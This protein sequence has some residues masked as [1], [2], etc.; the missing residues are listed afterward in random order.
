LSINLLLEINNNMDIKQTLKLKEIDQLDS[1]ILQFSKNTLITKRI[2]ASLL[3]AIIAIIMKVTDNKLDFSIYV[4]SAITLL[5]FWIID[6]HS[7]YYQ[8]LLRI[9]MSKIV[10]ELKN[11]ELFNGF[12]MPLA[13]NEKI[14]WKKSMFNNSQL[15]YLLSMV[16]VII[17]AICDL[18]GLF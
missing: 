8:R 1:A 5:V 3:V 4:A 14:T 11:D 10:K 7:Y 18:I 13:E 6:A 15:F 12:G 16:V 2:C 9:R 17:V